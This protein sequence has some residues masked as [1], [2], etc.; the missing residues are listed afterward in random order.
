VLLSCG[1]PPS[2]DLPRYAARAEELGYER[3]WV[4]DSPALY[5][6]VWLALG[7]VA[8]A[9]TRIGLGTGVAVPSLRHVMVTA[10][11]IAAVEELAPGRLACA[12]GTGF[13]ARR[14]MGLRPMTWAALG[15]YVA[16]L[17]ELLRGGVVEVDGARCRMLHSP[18]FAPS[19]PIEVPLLLAPMGPKGFAVSRE[20]ADGVLVTAPPGDHEW[21]T[22]ALLVAGT[23]V[24]DGEDHTSAR[25]VDAVG[26]EYA[27]SVHARWEFARESVHDMPGGDAW[28]AAVEG[29]H[30]ALEW[31]LAVHEG[32]KVAVTNRDRRIVDDAGPA[33]LRTGWTGEA[34]SV[35]ER[36]RDAA[37]NGVTE[38]IYTPA[39]SGIEREL[40]AFAA[41][42][43]V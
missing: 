31:H 5:G 23:V 27:T 34:A 9:T 38:V 16:N 12:F 22:C 7:R 42:A 24:D 41:A 39:G 32:H 8:E 4:Y 15:E 30:D 18:G 35:R 13:T 10:S 3:I 20:L 26:P 21:D 40:G 14:A 6:D 17:R 36:V 1:F 19:R 2:R 37:A 28:L 25:V 11:A 43:R 33:L 29:E